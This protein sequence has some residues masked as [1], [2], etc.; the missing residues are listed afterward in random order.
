MLEKQKCSGKKSTGSVR[1]TFP[2][3]ATI[4]GGT[5]KEDK[6]VRGEN[7]SRGER[8]PLGLERF[9][10]E[11]KKGKNN[12]FTIASRVMGTLLSM[13]KRNS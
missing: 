1:I 12:R 9:L 6:S 5:T 4:V 8:M 11:V 10:L 2:D 13:P 3:A 7:L